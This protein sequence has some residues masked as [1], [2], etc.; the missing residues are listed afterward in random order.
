MISHLE[1]LHQPHQVHCSLKFHSWPNRSKYQ[2]HT[3]KHLLVPTRRTFN[4]LLWGATH[5]ENFLRSTILTVQW[6]RRIE[7]LRLVKPPAPSV[8]QRASRIFHVVRPIALHQLVLNARQLDRL[9]AKTS[10]NESQHNKSSPKK[11]NNAPATAI[12]CF[13]KIHFYLRPPS[14]QIIHKPHV[15]RTTNTKVQ[16]TSV[17]WLG[18]KILYNTD[19]LGA[20]TV[21]FKNRN[22]KSS[23]CL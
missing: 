15:K 12:K 1:L 18:I 22:G 8:L 20:F 14:S 3:T 7:Q 5:I 4:C 23:M 13:P 11:H 16:T 10:S 6:R 2:L 19:S 21:C 9:D 17:R